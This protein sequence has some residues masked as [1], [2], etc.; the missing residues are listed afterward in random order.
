MTLISTANKWIKYLGAIYFGSAHDYTI[1][2]NEFPAEEKWFENYH[3]CVD[4]GYQ[5]IQ[6]KYM[7]KRIE[8]PHKKPKGKELTQQQKSENRQRSKR[9]VFVENSIGG[10]KRFRILSDRLRIHRMDMYEKLVVVCAGLWNF[11]LKVSE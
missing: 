3:I 10:L 11:H 5:G 2:K 7:A 9:R 4:L 1:L 6:T 8:I